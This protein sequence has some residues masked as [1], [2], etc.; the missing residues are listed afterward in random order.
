MVSLA[1][2]R[3]VN[4]RYSFRLGDSQSEGISQP[5][6]STTKKQSLE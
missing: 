6:Q 1:T 3:R 5:Q 2:A 4:M